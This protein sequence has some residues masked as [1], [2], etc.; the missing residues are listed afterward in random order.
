MPSLGIHFQGMMAWN[1]FKLTIKHLEAMSYIEWLL[2]HNCF[3]LFTLISPYHQAQVHNNNYYFEYL[4]PFCLANSGVVSSASV[5]VPIRAKGFSG[6]LAI[7]VSC[8]MAL[9]GTMALCGE[10]ALWVS[11]SDNALV[12]C[13]WFR[14]LLLPNTGLACIIK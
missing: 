11:V 6:S 12:L 3:I 9:C 5:L 8:A 10:L 1:S 2:Q 13:G 4:F 14:D 7:F